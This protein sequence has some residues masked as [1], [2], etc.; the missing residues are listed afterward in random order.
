MFDESSLLIFLKSDPQF[1]I[2]VHDNGSIPRDGFANGFAG[3]QEEPHF[4]LLRKDRYLIPVIEQNNRPV[5]HE[6]IALNVKVVS[7][8]HFVRKR[9]L[10]FTEISLGRQ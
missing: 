10:F 5:A 3:N 8:F 7:S 9:I 4:M 2:G 1:F 6:W